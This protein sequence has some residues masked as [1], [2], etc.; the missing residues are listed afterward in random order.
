MQRF[1]SVEKNVTVI[2]RHPGA[3]PVRAATE[4]LVNESN[5]LDVREKRMPSLKYIKHARR[6]SMLGK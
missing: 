5:S 1:E 2:L 3:P 4:I 6:R